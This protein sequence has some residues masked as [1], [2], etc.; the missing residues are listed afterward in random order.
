LGNAIDLHDVPKQAWAGAGKQG[1]F[2][3]YSAV[4]LSILLSAIGVWGFLAIAQREWPDGQF[5]TDLPE[6]IGIGVFLYGFV[7][8]LTWVSFTRQ[9]KPAIGLDLDGGG[10]QIRYSWFGPL[11]LRWDDPTFRLRFQK[12]RR[13][14]NPEQSVDY[15]VAYFR[16]KPP[17]FLRETEFQ[18]LIDAASSAGMKVETVNPTQWP[19]NEVVSIRGRA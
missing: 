19:I 1:R 2:G 11:L 10:I 15:R 14:L 16:W 4:V 12:V 5:W 6:L 13:W 3:F 7:G 8:V 18:T 9:G 17:L